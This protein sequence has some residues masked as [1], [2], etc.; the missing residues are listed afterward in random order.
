LAYKNTKG[1]LSRKKVTSTTTY[2]G[3]VGIHFEHGETF[4]TEKSLKALIANYL[5]LICGILAS[6][7][8]YIRP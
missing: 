8:S 3:E 6:M 1:K 5:S 4:P 2:R 7:L